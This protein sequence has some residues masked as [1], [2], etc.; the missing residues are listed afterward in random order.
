[1]HLNPEYSIDK[2]KDE[3]ILKVVSIL[4]EKLLDDTKPSL[5]TIKIQ[6][7]FAKHYFDRGIYFQLLKNHI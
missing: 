7:Y 4:I 5:M 6:L 2:G 1:M 3:E